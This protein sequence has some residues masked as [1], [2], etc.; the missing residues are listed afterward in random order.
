MI[1]KPFGFACLGTSHPHASGRVEAMRA[2][3]GRL[4]GISER[5]SS[6]KPFSEYTGAPLRDIESLLADKSVDL[7]L[8]HSWTEEMLPLCSAA[9]DAGKPVLVEKPCGT[10]PATIRQLR[11]NANARGVAVQAGFNFRHCAA[12]DR[13]AALLRSG[14]LGDIVEAR[15]HGSVQVGEH[16]TPLTNQ[17]NDIGGSLY[18]I[19]CH[20]IELILYHFGLPSSVNARVRKYGT[21]SGEDSRE[22]AAA[23]IF[24]YPNLVVTYD[25]TALDPLDNVE[26]WRL[27]I[28]GTNGSLRIGYLPEFMRLYIH[29]AR[30]DQPSG[31][32]S[33]Q[34][35]T[36]FDPWSGV[37]TTFSPDIP[38]VRNTEFFR[39]EA[40][41]FLDSVQN[42]VPIA[43]DLEQAEAVADVISACYDSGRAD[44][45]P[46]A[47]KA[48]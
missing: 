48:H 17:P 45:A 38:A 7:V 10:G 41:R 27:D 31:W 40:E 28:Y 47:I 44:G 35:K 13:T 5:G 6:G 19:G 11:Q 32:T 14:A 39:I 1:V 24:N 26:A 33:W 8:V 29:E 3:G 46:I 43:V 30:E 16:R 12:V 21:L 20:I 34:P 4:I 23:A 2:L 25:F 22:D 42:G 18:V 9:I 37:P 15:G 36:F